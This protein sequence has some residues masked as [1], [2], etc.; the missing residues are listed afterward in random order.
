MMLRNA[1]KCKTVPHKGSP[2]NKRISPYSISKAIESA[3]DRSFSLSYNEGAIVSEEIR[4]DR[5][6]VEVECKM[7]LRKQ[8]NNCPPIWS[9][10]FKIKVEHAEKTTLRVPLTV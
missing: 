6:P 4:A 9:A 8:P 3:K 2:I 1:N 10:R 7:D 5:L